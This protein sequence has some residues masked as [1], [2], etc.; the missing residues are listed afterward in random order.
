MKEQYIMP[1]LSVTEDV[2]LGEGVQLRPFCNL[3][4]CMIGDETR[5]GAFVEIQKGA[6]VG[7]RCKI[8]DMVSICTGTVIEDE[9]FIG[10][11]VIFTNDLDPRATNEDGSPKD[12]EDW[13][14]SPTVVRKGARIGAGA[15][16]CPGLTIG[17]GAFVGA[18]SVVTRDVPAGAKCFGNPA[19]LILAT[20]AQPTVRACD[21]VARK[22]SPK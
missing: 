1:F 16:I 15:V 20:E 8:Q 11:G 17:E 3:Y 12:S 22:E 18:G 21:W 10:P 9:V 13:Q 4:G 19:R 7:K 14:L 5:V 6:F 2:R